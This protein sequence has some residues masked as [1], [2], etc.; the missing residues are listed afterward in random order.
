[1]RLSHNLY[2]LGIY[3]D[4]KKTITSSSS[5][6]SKISS[7]LKIQCAKDNPNK[8]AQNEGL[9]IQILNNSAARK[10]IQDTNS[11]IQ[12]FDG[13][14]QQ[15]NNSLARLKEL[16]VY[17]AN[18]NLESEDKS[19]L[20]IEINSVLA[21]VDYLA[22]N[23]EFNKIKLLDGT[24]D[25]SIKSLVGSLED[26][27][28]EVPRFD[29]TVSKLF[30][31]GIDVENSKEVANKAM[32]DVDNAISK[33]TKARVTYGALQ[34][35]IEDTANNMDQMNVSLQKSQSKIG[36]TDIAEEMLKYSQ[37]EILRKSSI[38]LMAQ[39]NKLPQDV[40]RTLE[41]VK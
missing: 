20:Q 7:G 6:M 14:M 37:S 3:N 40:L 19:K 22:K 9:K 17:A 16:T 27:N 29:L 39:S 12:T 26:E 2:S 1:M 5:S 10:N 8:M 30:P 34:V 4:Y 21:D 38:A 33:V 18:G 13:G 28:V 35:N 15:M 23:T 32:T 11:M 25:E 41:N 36:D 31:D 24:D